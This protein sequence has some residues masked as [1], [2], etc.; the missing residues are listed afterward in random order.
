MRGNSGKG[1]TGGDTCGLG[2]SWDDDATSG[3]D[4]G[5]ILGKGGM[6]HGRGIRS[7]EEGAVFLTG[8]NGTFSGC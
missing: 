3:D 2:R 5:V 4:C 6:S 8:G 1:A 7:S